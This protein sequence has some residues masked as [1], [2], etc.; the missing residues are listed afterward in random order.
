MGSNNYYAKGQWNFTCDL[1][2]KEQK[3]SKGRKTWDNR[4]VC[5]SHREVR[6]PQDFVRGVKDNQSVPWSRPTPPD[7]FLPSCTLRGTNAIPGYAVP[8]CAIPSLIN[9]L[10]IDQALPQGEWIY[11]T[12]VLAIPSYA[13]PGFAVPGN[14]NR[15]GDDLSYVF[16]SIPTTVIR[17]TST[18]PGHETETFLRVVP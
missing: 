18:L 6:N 9:L 3:S 7:Q 5:A 1:C 10:F 11:S 14:V 8:G 15:G 2:G 16:D 17:V 4:Y 12:A 13:L